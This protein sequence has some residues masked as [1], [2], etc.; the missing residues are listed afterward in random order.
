LLRHP[1]DLCGHDYEAFVANQ[2]RKRLDLA[3]L[4]REVGAE[5][6]RRFTTSRA[7]AMVRLKAR[8][9]DAA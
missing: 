8:A 1:D 9:K 7:V 2:N 5:V 6:V 3:G 4:A